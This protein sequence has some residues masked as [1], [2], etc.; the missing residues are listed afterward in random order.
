MVEMQG[1]FAFFISTYLTRTTFIFD[2]F[3]FQF[4][5]ISG[6]RTFVFTRLATVDFVLSSFYNIIAGFPLTYSH[7]KL[8]K[9]TLYVNLFSIFGSPRWNR[10][11]LTLINSQAARLVRFGEN[12]RSATPEYSICKPP[13]GADPAKENQTSLYSII[14]GRMVHV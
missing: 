8:H 6:N 10:T 4:S 12:Y 3:C 13:A 1:R 5:S 2:G 9:L 7:K 14:G 11:T